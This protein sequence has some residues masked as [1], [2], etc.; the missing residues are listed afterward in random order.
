MEQGWGREL[1][2]RELG[3][4]CHG[5]GLLVAPGEGLLLW[6]LSWKQPSQM[7]TSCLVSMRFGPRSGQES[8]WVRTHQVPSHPEA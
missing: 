8:S 6:P 4:S 5:E 2:D 7:S 1:G 3:A